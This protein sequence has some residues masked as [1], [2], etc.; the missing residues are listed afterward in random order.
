MFCTSRMSR[1]SAAKDTASM[2]AGK[3]WSDIKEFGCA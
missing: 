2:L 3:S 1:W